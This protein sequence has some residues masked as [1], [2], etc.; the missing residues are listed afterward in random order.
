MAEQ[1]AL[2]SHNIID[3]VFVPYVLSLGLYTKTELIAATDIANQN[4][5]R[6]IEY[7]A[8]RKCALE[9]IKLID[10]SCLVVPGM[11]ED[12]SPQWP[13]GFTGSITHSR[14]IVLAIVGKTSD[15]D[16]VGVDI[17]KIILTERASRL[18]SRI[19][20]E[21]EYRTFNNI[22]Q[23]VLFSIVF[24]GKEALFKALY[25][26]T[27]NRFYFKDAEIISI[28]ME[29]YS[30]QIK[31]LKNL[32][33]THIAGNIYKGIFFIKHGYIVSL[34]YIKAHSI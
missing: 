21:T 22:S 3:K 10:P 6:K 11:H 15:F 25:P 29:N 24:S 33:K 20:I 16:S 8:G 28:D 2:F 27:R 26:L 32:S 14:G 19:A 7:S 9:A 30:W 1:T 34:V 12:G 13:E 18:I 4:I 31:L 17:E 23:S 5:K